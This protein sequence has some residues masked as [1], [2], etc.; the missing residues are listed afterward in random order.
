MVE[1]AVSEQDGLW[2]AVVAEQ[3]GGGGPDGAG[4]TGQPGIDQHPLA[5]QAGFDKIHVY[6]ALNAQ[7]GDAGSNLVHEVRW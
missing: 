5:G 4:A 6:K 1:V 2:A 7:L 3:L